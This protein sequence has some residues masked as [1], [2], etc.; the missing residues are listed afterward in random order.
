MKSM[1]AAADVLLKIFSEMTHQGVS[2]ALIGCKEPVPLDPSS[3]TDLVLEKDPRQVIDPIL[4]R[5]QTQGQVSVVHRLHYDVPHCF[6]YVIKCAGDPFELL[7]LDCL[8]DTWGV[9]RYH[10]T[11]TYLLKGKRTEP[12]GF[13]TSEKS[14]VLYFLVKRAIKGATTEGKFR[15]L[16]SMMLD[17]HP[18]VWA[19][20]DKWFGGGGRGLVDKLLTSKDDPDRMAALANLRR[21]LERRFRFRHPLRYLAGAGLTVL[22]QLR[23]VM[24]PTGLFIVILGPDGSGKS[25]AADLVLHDMERAFR[26]TWRFHWRPGFL[27]KLG[28]IANRTPEEPATPPETS[29]YRGLV[30]LA[31][32]IYYWLDFVIGYWVAIYPA[33][34]QT[35]LVVGERYFPDVLVTPARYG[36]AVPRPLMRLAARLVPSPDLVILLKGEPDAIHLRKPE[37]PP[38]EI[39]A[40]TQRY[41]DEIQRWGKH[42]IVST[43]EGA[44]VVAAKISDLILEERAAKTA[45]QIGWTA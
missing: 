7:F 19:D 27:R 43:G 8:H 33:M 15:V 32:F 41:E 5:M 24:K 28:R 34:A 31:R 4:R 6:Y 12:W 26:R 22:R 16:K 9:G 35:G 44:S 36:F 21:T 23:R 18:E 17:A 11:S 2:F 38:D 37:L 14:E 25:T 40:L 20:V 10:L 29:K 13:R 30:S 3:D 39:A 42:V 1:S 45:G